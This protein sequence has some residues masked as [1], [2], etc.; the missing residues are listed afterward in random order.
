MGK[1]INNSAEK[2]YERIS[3][4]L[5]KLTDECLNQDIDY[6]GEGSRNSAYI[7]Y[8][9]RDI[10]NACTIFN[11]ILSNR[12]IHDMIKGHND[13]EINSKEIEK[14]GKQIR[15]IVLDMTKLDTH[16]IVEYYNEK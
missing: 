5:D 9:N 12:M 6:N 11:S 4:M 2:Q 7:H 10:V 1:K 14:A 16:K 3:E 8:T 15:Q 13:K